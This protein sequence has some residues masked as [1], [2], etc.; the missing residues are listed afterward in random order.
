MTHPQ[1]ADYGAWKSPITTELIVAEN[2][3]LS[4]PTLDGE[5][6]YWLEG[7][8]Q[9]Q[10]RN[11]IVRRTPD[12]VVADVNPAP[13]DARTRVHEYG[14]GAYLAASGVVYFANFADQRLYYQ[15]PGAAPAPLTAADARRYADLVM[16]RARGRLLCICED[17]SDASREAVNSVA[18]VALDTGKV[19]TLV[20]GS[21]FYAAP[22]LSPDGR[23]LAWL[24]WN[25]PDMPWDGCELWVAEIDAAG[26]LAAAQRVAGSR[27]E[28]IA[29]PLW[30]PEG[31]LH[32]ISDRSNWWNLY[33]W[34]GGRVEALYPLEAEFCY[35]QW[36]FGMAGYAFCRQGVLCTY[37]A[38]GRSH[39][40]LL[41]GAGAA[42]P[43][44]LPYTEIYQ[45]QAAGEAALLIA[46]STTA[47][48]A[49]VGL[50]LASGESV[51][52]RRSSTLAM[53]DGHLSRPQPIE[54]PTAG[55][56]RA[57]AFFYAPRNRDFAAPAGQRPPL[58]VFSHGG[59][60]GATDGAFDI[61]IQYWTSRGFAVVDVNY[62]G[63][64]GYGRAY[65]QRLNGQW[66]VVDVEDCTHAALYLAEQ[67]LVDRERLAIRGGSAG[68]YTTL[69]C[70]VFTDVFKAG[71]SYFGISDL[72]V[73][74]ETHKFESHYLESLVGPY[75]ERRDLYIARS[76]IHHLDRLTSA[77][78]VL[79]GLE[80][81]I[82]LPNQ[83]EMIV[84]AARAKGLPVAYLP[85]AG[86][87]HGFRQ[88][89]TI[90]RA[91]DAELSFYAQVFGIAL[92]EAVE[93]VVVENL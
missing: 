38:Q 12:G 43:V 7:R 8:P 93:G 83:A 4:Q 92:P 40:A 89:A 58:L 33:R 56:K 9:E 26:G 49:V 13:F 34:Q 60:T 11:V 65:R 82:V 73:F 90:K 35:P 54:F 37:N 80:D 75:P 59:P 6:I 88:A 16:D 42:R 48:P 52:L 53:D 74:L 1:M 23:R 84:E 70:L 5:D 39:L 18:A 66:G 67:G 15:T 79:Q 31:V 22:R 45:V 64:S 32:F 29:Q 63:S 57:H 2:I 86:E 46:A 55:G 72:D 20:A 14:G 41:E 61:R 36:V 91:L 68:G 47:P 87:Q 78:L 76:P 3:S 30:S 44:E 19:T 17:H 71:A 50:D 10:G 62:G 24:S 69:C 51:V 85:F 28:S 81:K 77:L 21:D 27:Q 25:H